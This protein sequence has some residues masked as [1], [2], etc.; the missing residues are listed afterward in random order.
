MGLGKRPFRTIRLICPDADASAA[1]HFPNA[2]HAVLISLSLICGVAMG[3][4]VKARPLF[5]S[6]AYGPET[7]KILFKGFDGA[8]E[9]IEPDVSSRAEAIDVARNRLAGVVL[10]LAGNG[11][12]LSRPIGDIPRRPG[13]C[14]A[15]SPTRQV[16]AES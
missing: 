16:C 14:L 15:P 5:E 4:Q 8:W 2:Q 13:A 7:L 1:G 9:Q 10:S 11:A 12:G 3:L 6:A